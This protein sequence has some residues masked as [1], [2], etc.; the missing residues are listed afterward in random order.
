VLIIGQIAIMR[1]WSFGDG[2][3]IRKSSPKATRSAP[4]ASNQ[5]EAQGAGCASPTAFE[6]WLFAYR[7]ELDELCR[8]QVGEGADFP[9]RK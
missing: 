6:K 1:L 7:R 4:T 5:Q 3:S 8:Q 2:G 9:T